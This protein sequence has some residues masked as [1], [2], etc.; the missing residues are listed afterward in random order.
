MSV[1]FALIQVYSVTAIFSSVIPLLSGNEMSPDSAYKMCSY[2]CQIKAFIINLYSLADSIDNS[3]T[4]AKDNQVK[5]QKQLLLTHDPHERQNL[6][7]IMKRIELLKP[8]SACGF[9]EI[10]KSTLTSIKWFSM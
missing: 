5:I 2:I 1:Y 4:A 7:Y 10:D 9:F 6:E 3:F 8:M